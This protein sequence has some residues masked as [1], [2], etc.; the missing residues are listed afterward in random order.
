MVEV[1]PG[2]AVCG[3]VD[4][5]GDSLGDLDVMYKLEVVDVIIVVVVVN[6]VGGAVPREGIG[7]QVVT[8]SPCEKAAK[9]SG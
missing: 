1:S 7:K 9:P 8:C 4:V 2:Q 6:G 3:R 5:V